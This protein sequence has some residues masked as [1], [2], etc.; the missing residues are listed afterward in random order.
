MQCHTYARCGSMWAGMGGGGPS[1]FLYLSIAAAEYKKADILDIEKGLPY[2]SL[3]SV[4]SA[5][6]QHVTGST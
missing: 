4:S 5:S 2:F 1:F 6:E 3:F